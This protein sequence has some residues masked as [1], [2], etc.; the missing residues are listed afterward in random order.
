MKPFEGQRRFTPAKLPDAGQ[1]LKTLDITP[2]I[3]RA[4]QE[5]QRMDQEYFRSIDRNERQELQ[6]IQ[7]QY[8]NQ[9][10]EDALQNDTINRLVAFAPTVQAAV[11]KKLEDQ[12][13]EAEL[14][15]KMRHFDMDFSELQNSEYYNQQMAQLEFSVADANERAAKAFERTQ[16]YEIAKVY[17]SLGGGQRIGFAKAHLASMQ[18]EWPSVLQE[19]MTSDNT[20]VIRIGDTE[21]TPASAR[22]NAQT[23][24]A[25]KA[26]YRQYLIDR[27]VTGVNPYFLEQFFTGGE[28]GARTATQKILKKRN[29]YDAEQDGY[30]N[31]IQVTGAKPA[32]FKNKGAAANAN[33]VVAAIGMMSS[34]G[35]P[36]TGTKKTELLRD[37]FKGQLEDKNLTYDT[38]AQVL[39]NTKDPSAPGRSLLQRTGFYRELREHKFTADYEAHLDREKGKKMAWESEGGL[40]QQ[41]ITNFNQQQASGDPVTF[42]EI[43]EAQSQAIYY[44]GKRDPQIDQWVKIN[45]KLT[46]NKEDNLVGLQRARAAGDLSTGMVISAGYGSDENLMNLARNQ[47]KQ[48]ASQ[49]QVSA[50]TKATINRDI[51]N[52]AGDKYKGLTGEDIT[53]KD[54]V[55]ALHFERLHAEEKQKLIDTGLYT[56]EA[57]NITN[58]AQL[59]ADTLDNVRRYRESNGFK[60]DEKVG[61]YAPGSDGD[62]ANYFLDRANYS[63]NLALQVISSEREK[64]Q[65]EAGV[66]ANQGRTNIANVDAYF[67]KGQIEAA[68]RAYYNDDGTVSKDFVL[69]YGVRKWARRNPSQNPLQVFQSLVTAK[70]IVDSAG[71]PLEIKAPAV[72]DYVFKDVSGSGGISPSLANIYLNA[73]SPHQALRAGV[74]NSTG[75]QYPRVPEQY[76]TPLGEVARGSGMPYETL[77]A[78]AQATSGF[79][80]AIS[81]PIS[82]NPDL[83]IQRFATVNQALSLQGV[84]GDNPD[85]EDAMLLGFAFGPETLNFNGGILEP[86]SEQDDYLARVAAAKA[87]LGDRSQLMNPSLMNPRLAAQV[88]QNRRAQ[89]I[90]PWAQSISQLVGG[91]EVGNL[92]PE[93]MYPSTTLPGAQ[94]M[95]IAN[96]ASIATGAVGQYQNM[97]RFLVARAR[98][99]GLDP[100]TAPYN[101]ENQG[102]IFMVTLQEK[103]I[104]PELIRSNP[105]K[106]LLKLSQIYAGIPKDSSGRSYYEGD[107]VNK[108]TV[109]YDEAMRVLM[110]IAQQGT[111]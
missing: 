92:G 38:L 108:A 5:Q 76:S 107:G 54:A 89:S 67:P 28:N 55:L 86:T 48:R 96:V 43:E 105:E 2:Q 49:A 10:R 23:G 39:A 14:Q 82:S 27:G 33:D 29:D 57:G 111:N 24:A 18:G 35:K 8:E 41:T 44:T 94:Q 79:D 59:E 87:G 11:N 19:K 97:P 65:W 106:A 32:D 50:S 12:V 62:F 1:P 83:S 16:N 36:L 70:G 34:G 20:T 72:L 75:F 95:T 77:L 66:A 91:A 37:F 9:Q 13:K 69:P 81:E 15:G 7:T 31:F 73:E 93:A 52:V 71:N 101:V 102:K 99:A 85:H 47:E 110:A 61:L 103:G 98:K 3:S 80:T 53:T 100:N 88:R 56:D 109:S 25:A 90:A 40:R 84:Y 45:H 6:N 26:L 64:E 46:Q 22:G 68:A 58:E 4:F 104:T 74:T 42:K 21:F 17:K 60:A 30:D 51:R 78:V 63:E